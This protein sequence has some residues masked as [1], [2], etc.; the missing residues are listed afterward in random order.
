MIFLVSFVVVVW[1]YIGC[2]LWL[3][4]KVVSPL[5][6]PPPRRES[7]HFL[8][9]GTKPPDYSSVISL[10]NELSPGTLTFTK[11]D[12]AVLKE[13]CTVS[14]MSSCSY[15]KSSAK[16]V[17]QVDQPTVPHDMSTFSASATANTQER[18]V[19]SLELT[20]VTIP[21][22]PSHHNFEVGAH[23]K[24]QTVF[25]PPQT[26]SAPPEGPI[27]SQPPSQTAS[28]SVHLGKENLKKPASF[29]SNPRVEVKI[30]DQTPTSV[31][32]QVEMS[33]LPPATPPRPSPAE[34]LVHNWLYNITRALS[35][36][37]CS[38]TQVCILE[39]STKTKGLTQLLHIIWHENTD[40]EIIIQ[41]W[42]I[43]KKTH[44]K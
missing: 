36:S 17:Q 8:P 34:L 21:D 27:P 35:T 5:P 43:Q 18:K 26:S 4:N 22:P 32:S 28:F 15:F 14:S 33:K 41:I 29:M 19:S 13:S 37:H 16:S 39:T 44:M 24:I 23:S 20:P 6:L 30:A 9:T 3:A 42:G 7:F 10:S 38:T 1:T 2:C 12:R 11:N 31:P 25:S 40:G